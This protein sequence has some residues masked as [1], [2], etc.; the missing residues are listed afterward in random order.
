MEVCFLMKTVAWLLKN[1]FLPLTP[2]F[3]GA[4]ARSL[5]RGVFEFNSL[6]PTELSFSMA[7]LFLVVSLNASRLTNTTLREALTQLYQFGVITFLALFAW[8]IFIEADIESSLQSSLFA[9]EVAVQDG[10]TI[11]AE[12]LPDRIHQYEDILH[13]LRYTTVILALIVTPLTAFS[14]KKYD[15]ENL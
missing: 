12:A 2:F 8:A 13:R 10:V 1:L 6:S 4:L 14:A 7:M 5:H 15:L 11:T 9:M 3:V